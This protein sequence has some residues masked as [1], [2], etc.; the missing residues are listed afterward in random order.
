MGDGMK[1]QLKHESHRT[2][3][4]RAA[5]EIREL[6]RALTSVVAITICAISEVHTVTSRFG[7]PPVADTDTDTDN[8]CGTLP[9]KEQQT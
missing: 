2:R 8:T 6:L 1:Y 3:E 9:R 4:D 5:G 7:M